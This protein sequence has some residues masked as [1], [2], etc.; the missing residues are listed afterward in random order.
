LSS[1]WLSVQYSQ[2]TMKMSSTRTNARI[3][4]SE[5]GVPRTF[6]RPRADAYG[7]AGFRNDSVKGLFILNWS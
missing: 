3:D 6:Q 1:Q 4:T 5:H 2:Q 7:L